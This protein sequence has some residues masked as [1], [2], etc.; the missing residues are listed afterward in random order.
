VKSN[1]RNYVIENIKNLLEP[2]F[3][4][5]QNHTFSSKGL[6]E[7]EVVDAL[8]KAT[9]L[10]LFPSGNHCLF[11]IMLDHYKES[12]GPTAMLGIIRQFVNWIDLDGKL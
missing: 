11:G 6:S 10:I 12:I 9:D 5:I 2:N 4:T 1:T 8:L 7:I 3:T